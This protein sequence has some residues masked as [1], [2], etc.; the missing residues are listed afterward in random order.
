MH[1]LK[2]TFLALGMLLLVPA[3]SA[4]DSN[5]ATPRY[6]DGDQYV[7]IASPQRYSSKGKVEVV[8]VFSYGCIHCAHFAPYMEKLAKSLPKGVTVHYVPADFSPAWE[9]FA[10]AF[11][12]AQE[13]GVVKATHLEVFKAKFQYNYPMNSLQDF[14][15]FYARHGVDPKAFLKAARSP[16]V[17]R[18]LAANARLVRRWGVM[19]TPSIIVDGKYRV[20]HVRTYPQVIAVTRWLVQRELNASKH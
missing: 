17:D 9:P 3:C 16:R 7:T 11:Y 18:E 2:R 8:E 12:A 14:A 5:P 19:A 20:A 13:F 4:Q 15:A 6:T 10:R 1:H